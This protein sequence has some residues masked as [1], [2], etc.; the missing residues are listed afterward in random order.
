MYNEKNRVNIHLD[1]VGLKTTTHAKTMQH[2][3]P[4]LHMLSTIH[5]C[6]IVFVDDVVKT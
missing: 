1:H 2:F 6:S 5:E 3:L 4:M